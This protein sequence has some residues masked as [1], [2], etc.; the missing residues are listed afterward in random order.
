[1]RGASVLAAA[2]L[3][4]VVLATPAPAQAAERS[5]FEID[6]G[7]L[8]RA[9]LTFARQ[10]GISIAVSDPALR[11]IR[12]RGLKGRYTL[13][14]GLGRLLRG[15]GY[16]FRISDGSVVELVPRSA[17]RADRPPPPASASAPRPS[18][19]A[20]PRAR[21]IIVTATKQDAALADY[22]GSVHVAELGEAESLRRGAK[23]SEV[24]L[25]ELPNLTTTDLGSGR[26]KIFIRG[27]ADSSFN[28]QTQATISQYLG[29]SRLIYSAPD[30][31]LALYDVERVEV[32]EGPQGTLYGAGS[33]GGVIR[34]VPRAPLA[35][36]TELIGSIAL[37]T[38]ASEVGGDAA[39]VA[40]VP[41]GDTA[42]LR[43]VGYV[44]RRP[45]YIDD[46]QRGLAD[47]N[48]TNV[49]GLRAT[50]RFEPLADIELE[51]GIA[52]QN[53]NEP[54]TGNIPTPEPRR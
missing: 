11:R 26:N 9:L 44:I 5:A 45:G 8:D 35:R 31:D 32:L 30:P 21:T 22:P 13:R 47:I 20:P 49:S 27:I 38:T 4:C 48:R 3:A 43:V 53:T 7:P 2:P 10:A 40:N 17:P 33:L 36:V 46:L 25:R 16:D 18:P 41:L 28:G 50:V 37:S 15:S 34:L 54:G 1:M 42:A 6:A 39:L 52:G 29:E 23:G 14:A 51:A 12:V 19:P 24:L